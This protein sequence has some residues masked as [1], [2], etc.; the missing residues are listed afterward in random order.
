M[1]RDKLIKTKGLV[2]IRS[3]NNENS[4]MERDSVAN[5]PWTEA[6]SLASIHAETKTVCS[7]LKIQDTKTELIEFR[8]KI[9][10]TLQ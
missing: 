9:N 3:E 8:D 2:T 10:Q 4:A 1:E 5:P 7:A 6:S